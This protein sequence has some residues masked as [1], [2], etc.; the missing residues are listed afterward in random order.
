MGAQLLRTSVARSQR[1]LDRPICHSELKA[2]PCHNPIATE[3]VHEEIAATPV[4]GRCDPER[5]SRPAC[6]PGSDPLRHRAAGDLNPPA[7]LH[8]Y[9]SAPA[10]APAP[11]A[12]CSKLHQPVFMP[13]ML[14]QIVA[15]FVWRRHVCNPVA[16]S[17]RY[18][19][20]ANSKGPLNR[21]RARHQKISFLK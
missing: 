11:L 2:C 18:R 12:Q 6:I 9:L 4:L 7:C 19:A 15:K 13:L 17:D 5:V 10:P 21:P 8:V 1:K 20:Q 3:A 14:C 16:P